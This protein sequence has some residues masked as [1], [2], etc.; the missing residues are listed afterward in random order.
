MRTPRQHRIDLALAECLR[1]AAPYLLPESVLTADAARKVVPRPTATELAD[2]L[3]HLDLARAL[4]SVVG[5]T[6]PGYRLSPLGLA[7][8]AEQA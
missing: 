2:S 3:R 7:W 1:D 8:L 6:E 4:T 5:E